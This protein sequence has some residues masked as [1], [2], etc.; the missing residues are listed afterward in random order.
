MHNPA[1]HDKSCRLFRRVS[2]HTHENS[3]NKVNK[4]SLDVKAKIIHHM[5]NG[6]TLTKI[7]DAL[8]D[9]ENVKQPTRAQV[10]T[11]TLED[12][13]EYCKKYENIPED[14]NKAFVL[15]LDGIRLRATRFTRD[16]I[17]HSQTKKIRR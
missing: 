8:R 9:D 16:S 17:K 5:E 7:L 12:M 2:E 15:A 1:H 10:E 11:V 14:E 13:I 3:T 6:M 4:I